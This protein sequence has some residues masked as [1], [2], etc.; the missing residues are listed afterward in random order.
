MQYTINIAKRLTYGQNNE[1]KTLNLSFIWHMHQPDYRDNAGIMKMPWVFLHA[2]KDYFDMPW[3]L[4]RHDNIKATFNITCPLIEQLKLYYEKPQSHDYF[5]NLWLKEINELNESERQWMIKICKSAQYD[6]MI[7]SLPHFK[8]LYSYTAYEDYELFDMQVLFILSWCGMYLR[9]HNES[10]KHLM[11]KGRGFDINDK[12]KLLKELSKFIQSIFEYYTSLAQQ[13]RISISTTPLNHPILPLL[14]DMNNAITA[15]KSTNIPRQS[16]SLSE[17]A[18]A[19]VERAQKLFSETFGFEVSGFWPAEGAVDTKSVQLLQDCG[20]KWIATDEAILFKSLQNNDRKNLYSPYIYDNMCI[21][22][23]DH[24]LSDLIGFTYRFWDASKAGK[25]FINALQHIENEN[26]NGTV[27]VILDGENAWEF[28][29]NNGFDFFDTLYHDLNETSWC[30]TV[31]M[32]EVLKLEKK[33]LDCLSPGSWINGEFNTWVGHNEKTR[34]WDLIYLTKRDFEHHKENLSDEIKNKITDEFLLAEC[35]DWFWWYG[36]DHYTEFGIEFDD[37]FRAH[38]ISIYLLMGVSPPSD[39]FEPITKH[40]SSKH[41]LLPPQSNITPSLDGN[42]NSFFEWIGCGIIDE[43]KL[44]ST[45][46]KAR[47][48]IKKILYGQDENYLYFAFLANDEELNTYDKINIII[49]P[50]DINE[51]ISLQSCKNS[52]KCKHLG[53]L[54]IDFTIGKWLDM[55]IDKKPINEKSIKCRF[56]LCIGNKIIQT[57]PGFGELDMDI[58][59]DYSENWFI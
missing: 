55:R 2:I 12:I 59:N 49:D 47:G 6:T 33:T 13:G 57:L 14:I 22:F 53:V 15:N 51:H 16:I 4:S 20:I 37:L 34:A 11:A 5:L 21:G 3:M 32:D 28:Y 44:F 36:D 27:F 50:L 23:R 38:L 9:T 58:A 43:T 17:D 56:E 39:L 26:P 54:D 24:G 31:H 19:Q 48:P 46:D 30:Q 8:T 18:K 45:M 1:N 7:S 25:H 52:G 40:K 35:S 41:F 10:V 42:H 29:K